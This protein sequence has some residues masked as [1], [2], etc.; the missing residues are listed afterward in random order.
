[1]VIGSTT[2][3]KTGFYCHSAANS[4]KLSLD[5]KLEKRNSIIKV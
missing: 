2:S 4:A 5:M 3:N 1:M